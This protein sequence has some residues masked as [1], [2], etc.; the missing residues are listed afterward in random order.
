[1]ARSG[2]QLVIPLLE[3]GRESTTQPKPPP[4]KQEQQQQFKTEE[5]WTV[6]EACSE[7]EL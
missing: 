4:Q 3:T 1:M 5:N 7:V 6:V 2:S